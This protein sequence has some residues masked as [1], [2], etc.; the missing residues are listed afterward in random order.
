MAPQ[1]IEIFLNGELKQVPSG[2]SLYQLIDSLGLTG[3]PV[4]AEL[5][6][7]LVRRKVWESNTLS[8]EDRLEIVHFVGGG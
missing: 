8:P 4:A 1:T 5:N 2:W 7:Q 6:G 3:L